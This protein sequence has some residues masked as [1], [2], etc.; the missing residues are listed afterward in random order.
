MSDPYEFPDLTSGSSA[1]I[2]TE[3]FFANDMKNRYSDQFKMIKRMCNDCPVLQACKT[4]A[5]HVK[6]EGVWAG[7][8][9]S[10][11]ERLRK[12]EGIQAIEMKT[13]YESL[14]Q[15]MTAD[16]INKRKKR[17]AEKENVA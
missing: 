6:V 17:Q 13:Q 5:L 14:I 8:T 4:Y 10:E 16:A 9:F 12:Q 2:N 15:S 11:R 3:L 1:G 7:T